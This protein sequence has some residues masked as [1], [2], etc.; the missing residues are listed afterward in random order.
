MGE[1]FQKSQAPADHSA[2]A[3][4]GVISILLKYLVA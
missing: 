3:F 4:R 2:F 1:Q